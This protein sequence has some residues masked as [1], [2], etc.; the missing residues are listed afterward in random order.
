MNGISVYFVTKDL[1][2]KRI[3][4]FYE[5]NGIKNSFGT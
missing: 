5:N 2:L 3:D 4:V 1:Y